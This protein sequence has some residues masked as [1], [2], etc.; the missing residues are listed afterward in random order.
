M[1]TCISAVRQAAQILPHEL[2][3]LIT[4][5][6]RALHMAAQVRQGYVGWCY[7]LIAHLHGS[8][9]ACVLQV[10]IKRVCSVQSKYE[11]RV[12]VAT[13]GE[14]AN[15]ASAKCAVNS[16]TFTGWAQL[17]ML[18][19]SVEMED[20]LED[21]RFPSCHCSMNPQPDSLMEFTQACAHSK[22]ASTELASASSCRSAADRLSQTQRKQR[23]QCEAPD[24]MFDAALD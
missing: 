5:L 6:D 13:V 12:C 1:P 24:P 10:S 22:S 14:S 2:F 8:Q 20:K 3:I 15:L 9:C 19:C 11:E 21:M 17:W 16:Q 23:F 4:M 18:G 7:M